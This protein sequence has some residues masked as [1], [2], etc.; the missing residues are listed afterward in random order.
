MSTVDVLIVASSLSVLFFA[1]RAFLSRSIFRDLED[2][3]I[4]SQVEGLFPYGSKPIRLFSLYSFI[5]LYSF[6][7]MLQLQ[8]LFA[9]VF[10]FSLNLVQLVLFEILGVLSYRCGRSPTFIAR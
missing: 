2:P 3:D 9:L 7:S 1:G 4:F 5:S 8:V 10:S 6:S